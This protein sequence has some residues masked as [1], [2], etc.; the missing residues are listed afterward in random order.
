MSPRYPRAVLGLFAFVL[1]IVLIT[2]SSGSGLLAQ[3]KGKQKGRDREK[4]VPPPNFTMPDHW[5]GSFT[6]RNIGPANMSGRITAI[7]AFEADP[8]TY[9]VA[10]ASGGLLKTINNGI[11]FQH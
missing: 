5:A 9:Y 7:S 11:T 4:E 2:A 3:P 10:T 1:G 8:S 6:W